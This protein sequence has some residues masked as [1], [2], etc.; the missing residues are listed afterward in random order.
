MLVPYD[1]LGY[2]TKTFKEVRISSEGTEVSVNSIFTEDRKKK[3]YIN[4]DTGKWICFKTGNK[5]NFLGLIALL[6][7][8]SIKEAEIKIYKEYARKSLYKKPQELSQDKLYDLE[9]IYQECKEIPYSIQENEN[10]IVIDCWKYLYQRLLLNQKRRYYAGIQGSLEGRLVIPFEVNN[11]L[12]FYQGRSLYG[13]QPKYLNCSMSKKSAILYPF[14]Q[15]STE[16]VICEGPIDAI[17][18]HQAGVNATCIMG[19]SVSSEQLV[20]L[21]RFQG[22]LIVGFDNDPAGEKGLLSFNKKRL[23]HKVEDLF[24]I[25]PPTS[26]KDWNEAL[27]GGIDLRDYVTTHTSIFDYATKISMLTK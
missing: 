19:S 6:E 10:P 2:V 20:A 24:Y 9:L 18:L 26:Y 22:K 15:N 1:I 16:V 5:G 13:K 17:S 7:K 8:I 3:L 27:V 11:T 21:K 25:W 14:D 4:I 23:E 12:L